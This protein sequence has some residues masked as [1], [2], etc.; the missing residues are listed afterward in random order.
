MS[1]LFIFQFIYKKNFWSKI[2]THKHSLFIINIIRTDGYI[3]FR[4]VTKFQL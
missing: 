3:V 2:I 4:I 1:R